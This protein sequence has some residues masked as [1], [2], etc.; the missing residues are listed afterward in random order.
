MQ[1]IL[2]DHNCEGQAD[3]IFQALRYHGF[4][5][6]LP[7]QLLLFSQVGLQ[8][9]SSDREVWQFCQDNGYLLL[10]GNRTAADGKRSLEYVINTFIKEDSFPVVTI[11]NLDRVMADSTY[12][13]QCAENLAE[14]VLDLDVLRGIPRLFIPRH[15][16]GR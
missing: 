7:M 9:K 16:V 12:C 15:A 6:L 5:P 10:T 4:L 3:T 8:P 2:S 11:G 14:I 13:W 1:S